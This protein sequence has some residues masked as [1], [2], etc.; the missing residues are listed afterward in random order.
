LQEKLEKSQGEVYRLK[1]KL[2]N[3]Q[4]EQEALKAEL[5][6]SQNSVQRIVT[7]RDKV[8]TLWVFFF[9]DTMFLISYSGRWRL[10]Q[11]P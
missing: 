11:I 6:R 2:E 4:G 10:R 9:I 3:A 5:E 8:R 1:A 7:E